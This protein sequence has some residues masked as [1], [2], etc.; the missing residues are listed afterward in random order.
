MSNFILATAAQ[1]QP[2]QLINAA[3]CGALAFHRASAIVLTRHWNANYHLVA[4]F[5]RSHHNRVLSLRGFGRPERILHEA[6]DY[7]HFMAL[8]GS[9]FV[10]AGGIHIQIH[11]RATPFLNCV[12]YFSEQSRAASSATSWR[13]DAFYSSMDSSKQISLHRFAHG[14]SSS[15]S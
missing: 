14:V 4:L 8:V 5:S 10:V 9:L 1:I 13:V 12:F 11:G 3:F 7:I 2:N 6:G 15:S